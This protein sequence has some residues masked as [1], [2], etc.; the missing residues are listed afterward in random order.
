MTVFNLPVSYRPEFFALLQNLV[1]NYIDLLLNAKSREITLFRGC[2]LFL[3]ERLLKDSFD[4]LCC[5]S[6]CVC[7]CMS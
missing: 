4:N 7:V 3:F 5:A 1:L 6:L 2:F